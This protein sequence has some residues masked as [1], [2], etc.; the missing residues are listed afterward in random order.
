MA[1]LTT[2]NTPTVLLADIRKAIDTKQ[3]VT[4]SYDDAGDFTHDPDQWKFKAWLRPKVENGRL[5]FG[6]VKNQKVALTDVIY[7]VYHGR[8]IEMLTTHHTAR[9]DLAGATAQFMPPYDQF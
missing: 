7:G 1:I 6:I 8:F 5:V 9:F 3:V 2:T 4:W